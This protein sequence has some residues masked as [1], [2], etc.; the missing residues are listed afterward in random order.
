MVGYF[1]GLYLLLGKWGEVGS[2]PGLESLIFSYVNYLPHGYLL[3]CGEGN[4]REACL[5]KPNQLLKDMRSP[6]T[7][8]WSACG[9]IP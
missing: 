8:T 5:K 4:H 2:I 3:L 7:H 1:I 9:S 6:R